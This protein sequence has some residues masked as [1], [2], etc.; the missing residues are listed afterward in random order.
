[1]TKPFS[2][3]ELM[4]RLRA[5]LRRTHPL[6]TRIDELRFDDVRIDFRRYEASKGDRPLDL[7]RKEFGVLRLLAGRAADVV[8]RDELLNEVWGT[9]RRRRRERLTHISRRCGPNSNSFV[10]P[11]RLLTIHG[12]GYKWVETKS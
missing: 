9:S 2:V 1:M 3:G 12:V 6:K 7:T 10:K 4:A 11:R 8:T 5:L